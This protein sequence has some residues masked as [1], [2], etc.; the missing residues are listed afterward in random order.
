[1]QLEDYFFKI[2]ERKPM[3]NLKET[4]VNFEIIT[5]NSDSL[6]YPDTVH[7]YRANFSG[8]TWIQ[9]VEEV[10]KVLE[11][12]YGYPIRSQVYYSV[13]CPVFDHDY[14]S[15]PGRE[16]DRDIFQQLLK[17]YPELN[18]GGEHE[19]SS[20]TQLMETEKE[21]TDENTGNP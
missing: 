2:Q 18:N 1:M 9:I 13:K 19:P 21:S 17:N 15:A 8:P 3:D 10:L 4:T 11:A 6:D 16:I 14:A 12:S 5:D 7:S 20:F